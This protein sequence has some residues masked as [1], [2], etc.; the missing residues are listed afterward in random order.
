MNPFALSGIWLTLALLIATVAWLL[1]YRHTRILNGMAVALG[2][3]A[4]CLMLAN[5]LWG[6]PDCTTVPWW[7]LWCE[8]P[9]FN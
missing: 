5:L 3:A 7:V 8:W 6:A 4:L 2:G 9:T 1:P